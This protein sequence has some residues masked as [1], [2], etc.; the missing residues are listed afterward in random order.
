MNHD[1]ARLILG[2]RDS[3]PEEIETALEVLADAGLSITDR[4]VAAWM[5]TLILGVPKN[6]DNRAGWRRMAQ[7]NP[8]VSLALR[9]ASL[10]V[11]GVGDARHLLDYLGESEREVEAFVSAHPHY[12]A[13]WKNG[14]LDHFALRNLMAQDVQMARSCRKGK[15]N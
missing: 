14:R 5:Q 11:L 13:A 4:D 6:L 3:L 1:E 7:S 8:A 2:R 9:V 10:T 12:G 15:G